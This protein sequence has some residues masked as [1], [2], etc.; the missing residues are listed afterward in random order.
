MCRIRSS[1]DTQ[2]RTN[3]S[4]AAPPS[5]SRQGADDPEERGVLLLDEPLVEK[6]IDALIHASDEWHLTLVPVYDDLRMM[7]V[8]DAEGVAAR[9]ELLRRTLGFKFLV[10]QR[11]EQQPLFWIEK[12]ERSLGKKKNSSRKTIWFYRLSAME[13]ARIWQLHVCSDCSSTGNW[14]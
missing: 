5:S 3:D 1:E 10:R 7:R 2:R 12:V 9:C 8:G 4:A 13:C 11:S 14:H 6:S